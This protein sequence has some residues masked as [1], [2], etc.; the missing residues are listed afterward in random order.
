MRRSATRRGAAVWRRCSRPLLRQ[1][2]PVREL[3]LFHQ[4]DRADAVPADASA[5]RSADEA[6][7][8]IALRSGRLVYV[9]GAVRRRQGQ[10]HRLCARRLARRDRPMPSAPATIT[11]PAESGGEDHI[12][13][14]A[15]A[16]S[17]ATAARGRFALCIGAAMASAM[18]SAARS[19]DWLAAGRHV[20]MNGSRA[21]LPE[22]SRALSGPASRPDHDRSGG[23][24]GSAC[25]R[26]G[27][28]RRTR[29]RPD[30]A[31]R[32]NCDA[33]RPSG[34]GV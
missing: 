4:P 24:C 28:R 8:D 33:G 21:Y 2:V 31:C 23:A 6:A 10:H 26:A 9:I 16:I 18:A 19:I 27:A 32:A 34:T 14:H 13:D 15:G 3:C 12:R 20:V 5:F 7:A 30:P 1:P 11:R 29:S 17:S 25:W 22:A